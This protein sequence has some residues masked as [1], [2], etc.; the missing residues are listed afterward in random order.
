MIR[1]M[2]RSVSHSLL[3]LARLGK[4]SP[5]LR[6]LAAGPS[7]TRNCGPRGAPLRRAGARLSLRLRGGQRH[8]LYEWK[9]S[10]FGDEGVLSVPPAALASLPA[11][12]PPRSSRH[13]PLPL[14]LLPSGSG[15]PVSEGN[16]AQTQATRCW[17][18]PTAL[19]LLKWCAGEG[20]VAWEGAGGAAHRLYSPSI[21]AGV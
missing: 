1:C 5:N 19:L 3:H 15:G 6:P 10:A 7:R 13:G 12:Q 8:G 18:Q 16:V 20:P 17:S 21:G 4:L 2:R 11:S 9:H 14:G